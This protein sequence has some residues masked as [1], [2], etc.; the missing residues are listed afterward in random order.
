MVESV[1]WQRP[2]QVNKREV[3]RVALLLKRVARISGYLRAD[4]RLTTELYM[5]I[6]VSIG[7]LSNPAF[8]LRKWITTFYTSFEAILRWI[9]ANFTC[10]SHIPLCLQHV[11]GETTL[12]SNLCL[13]N[14]EPFRDVTLAWIL[15]PWYSSMSL[16]VLNERLHQW[17]WYRKLHPCA[18]PN[19]LSCHKIRQCCK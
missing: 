16:F 17:F 7:L 4:D 9:I 2:R 14:H 15:T 12:T 19:L 18:L 3:N 13:S 1:R 8:C 5:I 6:Y 11:S 10:R